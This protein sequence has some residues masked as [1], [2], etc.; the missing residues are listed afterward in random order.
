MW[1]CGCNWELYSFVSVLRTS[2]VTI[3]VQHIWCKNSKGKIRSRK[4]RNTNQWP[5]GHVLGRLYRCCTSPAEW[6]PSL[7]FFPLACC[8]DC[9]VSLHGLT[10]YWL[11]AVAR[12]AH[13][14]NPEMLC[15]RRCPA[16]PAGCCS[17]K[18]GGIHPPSLNVTVV[19]CEVP[20]VTLRCWEL[21]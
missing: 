12:W 11:L 4:L 14:V 7:F 3:P 10:Q 16:P 18:S 5:S 1:V 8:R 21:R 20:H 9:V 6:V 15:S 2:C 13:R 19:G 17:V